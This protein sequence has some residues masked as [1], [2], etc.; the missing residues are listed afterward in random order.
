MRQ[1]RQLNWRAAIAAF[2]GAAGLTLSAAQSNAQQGEPLTLVQAIALPD[3]RGRIDHL[4]IDLDGGR[5]F[6][7]ALGNDTVEVIDLR[8]GRRTARIEHLHE[9]QG[10]AYVPDAGRLFVANGEGGRVDIFAGAELSP[11]AHID[12]LPDADNVR[13]DPANGRVYVGYGNGALAVLDASTL[14]KTADIKLAGHPESFQLD[15]KG[16]H[17]YANVPSARQIAVVDAQKGTVQGIWDLAERRGN[18]PMALDEVNHRVF[19]VTR[20]PAALLRRG[21]RQAHRQR[22]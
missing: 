16:S 3:V 11:I 12:S 2:A 9:P 14:R 5:L 8:T 7:A 17:L 6:V 10:V 1:I 22:A 18:F 4:D 13:Y 21:E 19:V 15:S 20:R